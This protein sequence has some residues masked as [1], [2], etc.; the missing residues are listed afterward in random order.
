MR[1]GVCTITDAKC[2]TWIVKSYCNFREKLFGD[3]HKVKNSIFT[4]STTYCI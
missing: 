3:L 4:K 1:V 2:D